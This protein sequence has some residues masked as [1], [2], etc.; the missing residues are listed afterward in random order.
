VTTEREMTLEEWAHK[1]PAHHRARKEYDSL[2][3]LIK[4][5]REEIDY[6]ETAQKWGRIPFLY[7][8]RP[9]Q[10]GKDKG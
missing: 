7:A 3:D 1:L 4:R 6:Y 9:D 5:Q 10:H 8:Q 2:L